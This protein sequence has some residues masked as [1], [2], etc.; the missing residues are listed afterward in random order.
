MKDSRTQ[1]VIVVLSA[2]RSGT[3]LLMNVLG[4][5]GMSFSEDMIPGRYGNPE[6][7][8]EDAEIVQIHQKIIQEISAKPFL[9][10]P[11]NW[12]SSEVAKEFIP[13]LKI[14]LTNRL[15]ESNTIWGFK[16]PRTAA[17][18][19]LWLRVFNLAVVNPVFILAV[20]NPVAMVV[21]MRRIL[22]NDDTVTELQWLYRTC[23]ALHH[24]AADCYIV[25][26]E[27]WFSRGEE[28]AAEMLDYTGLQRYFDGFNS[29]DTVQ[30]II[31]GNLNRSVYEEYE[32]KNEYVLKLYNALQKCRGKDF[33][34]AA[35][36]Q[37]VKECRRGMRG[38]IGWSKV[39]LT[40][41]HTKNK[42]ELVNEV[43]KYENE[44]EQSIIICN[45][46]LKKIKELEDELGYLRVRLKALPQ[47]HGRNAHNKTTT[48]NSNKEL[49]RCRREIEALRSSFTY[50][51]GYFCVKAFTKP[52]RNSILL[53]Y[54]L[55]KLY[56][57]YLGTLRKG[58]KD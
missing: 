39:A 51:V 25:H 26:Y 4:R 20:R 42:D 35:L 45:S 52:G 13:K 31:K 58:K 54:R 12:S 53:P 38:F 10:L 36:M 43:K 28:I 22:D 21:S 24:T 15:E 27:D 5:L 1:D 23:E 17:L 14:L 44:L 2:G 6:G 37:T 49:V 50:R 56:L 47:S 41:S 18:L 33:D 46:Y 7:Y 19:P 9:P 16:D 3:S 55:I 8:F 32:V 30:G 57:K 48:G 40:A 11:D 34:R 29:A